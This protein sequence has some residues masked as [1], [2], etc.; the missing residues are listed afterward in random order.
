MESNGAN[1][2]R[3]NNGIAQQARDIKLNELGGLSW[4]EKLTGWW[5]IQLSMR[6]LSA[7][8]STITFVMPL[9]DWLSWWVTF[10]GSCKEDVAE[11][12]TKEEGLELKRRVGLLSGIA[13][14]IG[15]MIG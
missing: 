12:A 9:I 11:V 7:Q 2:L 6:A 5:S 15:N 8:V 1:I 4:L 13:L 14:I 3:S 10:V